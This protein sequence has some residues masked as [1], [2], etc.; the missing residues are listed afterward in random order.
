MKSNIKETISY[1]CNKTLRVQSHH[2]HSQRYTE[3]KKHKNGTPHQL[4]DQE[5]PLFGFTKDL[6]KE[7]KGPLSSSGRG[8]GRGSAKGQVS[9]LFL[10]EN[11]CA[12]AAGCCLLSPSMINDNAPNVRQ[13]CRSVCGVPAKPFQ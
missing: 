5:L 13:L 10:T 8:S 3:N 4:A 1:F 2:S 7:E 9:F 12:S 11:V 6:Q